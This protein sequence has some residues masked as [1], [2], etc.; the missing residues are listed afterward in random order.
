[1]VKDRAILTMANRHKAMWSIEVLK[2]EWHH[3]LITLNDQRPIFQV[4]ATI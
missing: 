4:Y 2:I 3:F 1:M